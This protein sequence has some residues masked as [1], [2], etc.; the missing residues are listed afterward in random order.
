MSRISGESKNSTATEVYRQDDVSYAVRQNGST[1][2]HGLTRHVVCMVVV[3]LFVNAISCKGGDAQSDE[4]HGPPWKS[5]VVSTKQIQVGG[6]TLQIDFGSGG[7]DLKQD[8]IVSW[9]AT[10]A[11]AVAAYLGKFP[12][13]RARVLILPIAGERGVLTGTS[14]GDVGGFPAFTRMRVGQ[15]TTT[16]DLRAD[17]MMTH[18]LVH[19]GFPSLSEKHH[20]LE[21][22]V[23][24]YVEPIAR[25]QIGTLPATQI[26]GDMNRDMRKGEPGADD[27]GLDQTHTWASTYWGGALF[28]MMADIKIRQETGNR[29]GL[30]DALR[31][32]V[33]ASGTIDQEWPIERA[34]AVGDKATGTSVLSRLYGSMGQKSQ[35]VNLDALWKELGVEVVNGELVMDDKAPLANI[36]KGITSP[37]SAAPVK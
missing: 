29:K 12:V 21:E 34:F 35:T 20:W 3:V 9:V 28:C 13:S 30:Q 22:G 17:W 18:E 6:S 16:D 36:R 32:I 5:V 25:V 1:M 15:H 8:D 26:W 27:K 33:S 11:Q 19:I 4:V 14:W 23:A 24:T 31:A 2:T 37:E 10:A 7:C